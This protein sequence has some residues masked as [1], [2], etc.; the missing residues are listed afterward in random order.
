[1]NE[2]N[3]DKTVWNYK[4]IDDDDLSNQ[5]LEIVLTFYDRNKFELNINKFSSRFNIDLDEFLNEKN[6]REQNN[7]RIPDTAFESDYHHS[8][9]LGSFNND[10]SGNITLMMEKIFTN[11][12]D[13]YNENEKEINMTRNDDG[14][15]EFDKGNMFSRLSYKPEN[16]IKLKLIR[17][18]N[19]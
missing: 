11:E 14:T 2:I 13:K 16:T 10:E 3:Y 7:E 1:M 15:L 17:A 19:D 6:S 8:L 18:I 12:Q 4:E 5:N 9:I